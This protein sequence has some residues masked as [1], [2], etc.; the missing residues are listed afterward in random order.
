MPRVR[1]KGIN[2][3]R[4]KLAGGKTA[5]YYYHRTT[6]IRLPDHA[7]VPG[8]GGRRRGCDVEAA[9]WDRLGPDPGVLRVDGV[10]QFSAEHP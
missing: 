3:V 8:R 2:T 10:G 9:G 4:A 7:G 5:T 1:L 6:G